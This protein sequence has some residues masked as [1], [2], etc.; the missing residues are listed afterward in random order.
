[1]PQL[2]PQITAGESI[3]IDRF[4]LPGYPPDG[5]WAVIYH[6][7]SSKT[8][9]VPAMPTED[10]KAWQ[11]TITSD[12]TLQLDTG[13]I[14]YTAIATKGDT[15]ISVDSG[16]LLNL[17]SPLKPS[18]WQEVIREVDKAVLNF[19]SNPTGSI[20]IDGM[21]MTYRS[22]AELYRIREYA[23]ERL[24]ADNGQSRPKVIRSR[25]RYM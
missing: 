24:M 17:P 25:L 11:L 4:H 21:S 22:M 20:T 19:A 23:T 10:G 5:G 16:T 9:S 18:H 13:R 14:I 3:N 2:P 15:S 1:M 6:F 12:Q 8:L 7:N